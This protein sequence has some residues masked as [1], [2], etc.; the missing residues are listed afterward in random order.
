[1]QDRIVKI[2]PRLSEE[3]LIEELLATNDEMNSAFT[4][5]QRSLHHSITHNISTTL[6]SSLDDLFFSV[7]CRFERRITNG[8]NSDQ[9]VK[10]MAIV[11]GFNCHFYLKVLL[12]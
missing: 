1:M 3:K 7:A 12:S 10:N 9:K 6:V 4:R 5:Y 8:Q 11:F 2:V